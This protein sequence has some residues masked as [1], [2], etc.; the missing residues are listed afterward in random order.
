MAFPQTISPVADCTTIARGT[1]L[2]E[3]NDD[4]TLVEPRLLMRA[5]ST[6][7]PD[8]YIIL[9]TAALQRGASKR[10]IATL[11]AG[12]LHNNDCVGRL[13]GEPV[14]VFKCSVTLEDVNLHHPEQ[15][16]QRRML[17]L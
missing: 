5:G 16:L 10:S 11:S 3:N 4:H 9:V 17:P 13:S 14:S 7:N 8:W 2:D 15:Q 12:I 6:G 1:L